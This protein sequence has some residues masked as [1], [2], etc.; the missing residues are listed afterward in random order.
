MVFAKDNFAE[1]DILDIGDYSL[2][3][4]HKNSKIVANF[5]V[6]SP[7]KVEPGAPIGNINY[8][9]NLILIIDGNRILVGKSCRGKNEDVL[10]ARLQIFDDSK[11]AFWIQGGDASEYYKVIVKFDIKNK[12]VTGCKYLDEDP[13]TMVKVKNRDAP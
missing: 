6:R 13:F 1:Q 8:L 2:Q 5:L 11:G 4:D 10:Y 9:K 7:L 3:L 12:K